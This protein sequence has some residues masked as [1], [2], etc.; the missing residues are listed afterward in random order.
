MCRALGCGVAISV[1]GSGVVLSLCGFASTSRGSVRYTGP[2]GS[3]SAMSSARPT[4]SS[5]G[6]PARSSKSH[7][8][9]SRVMPP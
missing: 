9:Y 8:V 4:I 2:R 6:C 5:T 7:L 1:G 3:D